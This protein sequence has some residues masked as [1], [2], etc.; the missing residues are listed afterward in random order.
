[1]KSLLH[2]LFAALVVFGLT[3]TPASAGTEKLTAA[4]AKALVQPFYDLL[5]GKGTT[6]AASAAL[7]EDWKSYYSNSGYKGVKK[8]MG[9]LSGPLRKMVPDLSWKI[10]AVSVT[11]NNE[12]VVRGRA[13][14]TPAGD[15]FFGQPV[16]GK[17]FT[18]MSLDVHSVENGKIV[19][20]YHIED[21]AGALKQLAKT[22]TQ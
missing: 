22:P 5:D 6:E 10:Q 4:E 9:F 19:K 20:T 3:A 11:D 18:I 1:M 14:G 2:S 21:W 12:I 13:K 7:H 15:R 16:S 17:S 8:T